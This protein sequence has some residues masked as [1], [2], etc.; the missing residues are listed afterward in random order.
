MAGIAGL[1]Q[2]S[3][4]SPRCIGNT[5]TGCVGIAGPR[6]VSVAGIGCAIV[7]GPRYIGNAGT[8]CIGGKCLEK[9]DGTMVRVSS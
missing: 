2:V 5:V 4:A 9:I 6:Y 1:R 3:T 8:G 7:A